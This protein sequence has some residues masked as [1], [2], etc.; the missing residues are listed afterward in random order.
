MWR[1]PP[2]DARAVYHA[3]VDGVLGRTGSRSLSGKM[4]AALSVICFSGVF[5]FVTKTLFGERGRTVRRVHD[6]DFGFFVRAEQARRTR[7]T[8]ATGG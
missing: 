3:V 6:E 1:N 4:R 8:S 7:R 5:N 2:G